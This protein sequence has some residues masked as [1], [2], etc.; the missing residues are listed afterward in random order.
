MLTSAGCA[1]PNL[2][3]AAILQPHQCCHF[4]NLQAVGVVPGLAAAADIAPAK[5]N[6]NHPSCAS[7]HYALYV[8]E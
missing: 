8:P 5:V 4:D 1:D 7:Q 2:G 3:T 6:Q